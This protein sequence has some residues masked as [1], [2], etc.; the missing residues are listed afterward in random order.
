MYVDVDGTLP[1]LSFSR[2]G[3][4][5]EDR[6]TTTTTTCMSTLQRPRRKVL[7]FPFSFSADGGQ[8]TP[9]PKTACSTSHPAQRHEACAH[10]F[11]TDGLTASL[12]EPP[13]AWSS[14]FRLNLQ[15]VQSRTSEIQ[16]GQ[17]KERETDHCG[18]IMYIVLLS[19]LYC[20]LCTVY[21]TEAV[22]SEEK[23]RLTR[24]TGYRYTR[25]SDP[26]NTSLV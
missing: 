22:D 10:L 26:P 16:H 25:T 21:R 13:T 20:V 24:R 9:P 11:T 8:L 23:A 6:C 3:G 1:S 17:K 7:F 18:I 14:L 12:S 5:G 2:R 15:L 19:S 4:R